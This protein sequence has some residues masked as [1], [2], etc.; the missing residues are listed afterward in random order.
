MCHAAFDWLH[1]AVHAP[2]HANDL[3]VPRVPLE[4]DSTGYLGPHSG[5]HRQRRELKLQVQ[6]QEQEQV[7]ERSARGLQMGF[8]F[9]PTVQAP[10]PV[11][12]KCHRLVG[13]E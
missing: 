13:F 2:R 10:E 12:R 7:Q 5:H 8:H 1:E 3:L 6:E 4:P 11:I 9:R